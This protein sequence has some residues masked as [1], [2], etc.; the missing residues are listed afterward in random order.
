MPDYETILYEE[1][2]GVA[3]VTLNR[4]EVHNAF[5]FQMQHELKDVW[6]SL[7]RNDDVRCAV[8]TG[9][10]DKAFCAGI[11]RSEVMGDWRSVDD[12]GGTSGVGGGGSSATPW[13]FDDPGQNIGP[14]TN[15]LWKPVIAAVNGM[16][17]AGAFYMLGEVDFIIAAEHATFFDPHVTFGMTA[18]FESMHMLQ[19][20][21]LGEIMRVALLGASER[22]TAQRAFQ[23]GLVSEVVPADG[24]HDAAA[25][26]SGEIAKS[27]PIA[28]QGTVRAIWMARELSRLQ[29]LDAG[30]VL[31]RLGSD[32]KSLFEGQQAFASGQRTEP[33]R[34]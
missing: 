14:K 7:R 8:L 1:V 19:K 22:M 9:A 25:W 5:N 20:M 3:W 6:Q 11:D 31:I 30:R 29:A 10:G 24:L 28:V 26:A 27:P 32:A 23:I 18:C 21:P 17:C 34:R 15:D 33:R 2:G 12:V 4:P 13:H 16:A